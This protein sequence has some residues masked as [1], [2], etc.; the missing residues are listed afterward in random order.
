MGDV[1]RLFVVEQAGRI[2]VLDLSTRKVRSEPFLTIPGLA[3]GNEQGLLGLAF[4]PNYAS[5]GYFYVNCTRASDG[6]TEIRRYQVSSQN[7]NLANATGTVILRFSQPY[8]NHNGGWIG[9]GPDGYLYIASGDGGS[10]NDPQNAA[11]DRRSLLGKILRIDVD[12]ADGG[13]L[14][15]IPPTNPFASGGGAPEVWHLGLR[16]PWRCSF[17]RE[18]GD[19]W[20]AD[21]GQYETEEVNFQPAGASGGLN[22]GWRVFEGNQRT[23]G[24]DDPA[25]AGATSPV[26]VYSHQIGQSI[27]GG[28]VFRGPDAGEARGRYI[29]GDFVSGRVWTLGRSNG[30]VTGLREVTKELTASG[31]IPTLASFAED[32]SGRLYAISLGGIVYRL[33]PDSPGRPRIALIGKADRTESASTATVR[34]RA[35]RGGGDALRRILYRRAGLAKLSRARGVG[36]WRAVVTLRPG[37]NRFRFQAENRSGTR[38][39][40]LVVTIRRR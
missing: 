11:Q 29:F 4:H 8:S 37:I 16:N 28:Y 7:R 34:G 17:D 19:F 27:T 22:F 14:Y 25:P 15:G 36:R 33:A 5:N 6:A 26:H 38:S 35:S 31:G 30:R 18:T 3:R 9:F 10:G 1:D 39:A 12:T 40:P 13:R 2:R 23:P 20:I 32:A 24:I 21:V